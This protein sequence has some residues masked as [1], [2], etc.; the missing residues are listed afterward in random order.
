MTISAFTRA[1][2]AALFSARP[3]WTEY[4]KIRAAEINQKGSRRVKNEKLILTGWR[5]HERGA[6]TNAVDKG[7]ALPRGFACGMR[8]MFALVG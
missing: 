8:R 3:W 7:G 6:F 5:H 4:D 1:V 2:D